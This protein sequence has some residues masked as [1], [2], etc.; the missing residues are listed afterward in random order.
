LSFGAGERIGVGRE[1]IVE[2]HGQVLCHATLLPRHRKTR[3]SFPWRAS[4]HL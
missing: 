4:G 3:L 2:P 1:I